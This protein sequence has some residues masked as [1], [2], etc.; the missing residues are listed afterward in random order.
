MRFTRLLPLLLASSIV[1]QEVSTP[2]DAPIVAFDPE[3]RMLETAD[4]D[5]DGD[6][7]A[8]GL[9][10]HSRDRVRVSAYR[11]DGLGGYVPAFEFEL[12][13]ASPQNLKVGDFDGDGRDDLVIRLGDVVR[14]LSSLG[15]ALA[16]QS[17]SIF[18]L[19]SAVG[20]AMAVADFDGDGLD[21]FA[22]R[23]S[24]DVLLYLR[25]ALGFA[26]AST[27]TAP[28]EDL[29]VLDVDGDGDPDLA[30]AGFGA[31]TILVQQSGQM[32]SAGTLQHGVMQ[33]QAPVFTVA[34]DIDGDGDD[35]LVAFGSWGRYVVMRNDG[36]GAFSI[37]AEQVGG[38]AT[39]LADLDGDGDLDGTC[40]SSGGGG[41]YSN[42]VA[43]VF[44]LS[45]NLGGGRFAT[46]WE[47]PSFGATRLAA[48]E[49][50]DGDGDVDLLAGRVVWFNRGDTF[51]RDPRPAT[52]LPWNAVFATVHDLDHDGDDDLSLHSGLAPE[53]RLLNDG[54]G[55][56]TVVPQHALGRP[57]APNGDTWGRDGILGD[58][59]GDGF[60]DEVVARVRITT[61]VEL[62]LL[63]G[64]GNGDRVDAGVA[65]P[66]SGFFPGY[67]PHGI[68]GHAF[69]LDQ[70]GDLDLLTRHGQVAFND[71][72][73]RF[74][75]GPR[76]QLLGDV[77]AVGDFDADG[78]ADLV[79]I[80][81]Q[82]VSRRFSVLYA[83]AGWTFGAGTDRVVVPGVA[84][85]RVLAAAAGDVDG[86]GDLDIVAY[87]DDPHVYLNQGGRTW[88]PRALQPVPLAAPTSAAASVVVRDLDADGVLDILL[89][90]T[91]DGSATAFYRGLGGGNFAAP[92]RQLLGDSPVHVVDVDADGDL[93]LLAE[94]LVRNALHGDSAGRR[95][96]Y[97]SAAAGA[98]GH[99][100]ML[101]AHGPFRVGS[102]VTTTVRG[103]PGGT[104]GAWIWGV[105]RVDMGFPQLPDLAYFAMPDLLALTV[106]FSGS[107]ATPGE[108]RFA[109]TYTVPASAFG[110]TLTQQFHILDA[111][112]P[113]GVGHTCGLEI[114]YGR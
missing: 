72:R 16:P 34:G 94:R 59:D 22:V 45:P 8:V 18:T 33:G 99:A 40:C 6:R 111:T 17:L 48:A 79:V 109:A 44:H 69:D 75:A 61:F 57:P 98:G 1:A 52:T 46:A 100:P 87:G 31:L 19:P 56:L 68:D 64:I 73:G 114:R 70:D 66:A 25:T 60:L 63:R 2:F 42:Q 92:V 41:G 28:A 39:G 30:A 26:L 32:Q 112:R 50:L 76:S 88:T 108:G 110:V 4:L 97:G 15:S 113:S 74:T 62:R 103:A 82:I 91:V 53:G 10:Q 102:P 107:G 65:A 9:F 89:G 27:V 36:R 105:R 37:E 71:G 21:D 43:S 95:V 35:D 51:L 29:D 54:A 11:N 3:S 58:F 78:R 23:A 24:N 93:D 13:A 49:D 104:F 38:P 86:D 83:G 84:N 12:P 85:G 20:D 80:D 96:Q 5:G 7:D 106:P 81:L 47:L 55:G 67:V 14:V 101:G 90:V 77:F